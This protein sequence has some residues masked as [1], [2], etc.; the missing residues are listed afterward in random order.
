MKATAQSPGHITGFFVI[1]ENGSTGA[2]INIEGGMK[3][4]VQFRK[5][6]KD[7]LRMNGKKTKLIVSEKVLGLFRKKA[8]ISAAQKVR[9]LHRTKFPIGYGLGISGAGA[10]SLSI[11]LSKLFGADLG[12]KE[13]LAIAKQAEI[14]CGT[15][16]G[17]VV[18]EQFAG[19][20]V[21]KKPYPSKA[22]ARIRANEK[23]VALGFFKAM[24]TKKIIRSPSWKR[25]INKTGLA[26]MA[27][28]NRKKPM[29]NFVALCRKFALESGLATPQIRNVMGKIPGS[30]MA[31]LG[32]TVFMPTTNPKKAKSE[33]GKYCRRA[34]IAKI[35]T[36]G[37]G[38]L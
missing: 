19:V 16:L 11:A 2:G 3:T 20:M 8:S 35:A 33:L 38:L 22:I 36:K 27:E 9:V 29:E 12:K 4:T 37:A 24:S 23:F 7:E 30:G 14:E 13:I 34:M 28:I 25:K 21:G 18:A 26:C 17:D 15:G 5:G 1:Y 6:R 31:M 32:E 10:L